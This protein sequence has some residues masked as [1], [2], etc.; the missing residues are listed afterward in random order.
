MSELVQGGELIKRLT[1][2]KSL[3]ENI[4]LN[5]IRQIMLGLNYLH[6]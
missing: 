6:S 5:I 3:T 4:A 2:L 1:K